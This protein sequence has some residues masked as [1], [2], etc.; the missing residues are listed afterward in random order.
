[1][2]YGAHAENHTQQQPYFHVSWPVTSNARWQ[3]M[4]GHTHSRAGH[5][6]TPTAE[7]AMV[8]E[9]AAWHSSRKERAT[10][11]DAMS[12]P[13]RHC[14]GRDHTPQVPAHRSDTCR[15]KRIDPSGSRA[16][17]PDLPR[18]APPMNSWCRT[19]GATQRAAVLGLAG[20]TPC[21][22]GSLC[23]PEVWCFLYCS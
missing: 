13:L 20:C 16:A 8:S 19:R 9:R 22:A 14:S 15:T 17:Q 5:G 4:V 7:P 18:H 2:H 1:M 11:V 12:H 23:R 3:R 21:M 6:A 10:C